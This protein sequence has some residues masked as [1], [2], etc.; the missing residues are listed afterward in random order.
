LD[1]NSVL[2]KLNQYNTYLLKLKDDTKKNVI[3]NYLQY[4]FHKGIIDPTNQIQAQSPIDEVTKGLKALAKTNT[5]VSEENKKLSE[6]NYFSNTSQFRE[7]HQGKDGIS[8]AAVGTKTYGV[9]SYSIHKILNSGNL[10]EIKTL[11]GKHTKK[12]LKSIHLEGPILENLRQVN[13]ALYYHIKDS[14]KSNN[15]IDDISAFMSLSVDNAKELALAALN[16]GFLTLGLY[17]YA[18]SMG[19][20][21]EKVAQALMSP[22]GNLILD[23]SKGNIFTGKRNA[24]SLESVFS[25]LENPVRLQHLF[26]SKEGRYVKKAWDAYLSKEVYAQLVLGKNTDYDYLFNTFINPSINS[27]ID[28]IKNNLPSDKYDKVAII[29]IATQLV[30]IINEDFKN[31]KLIQ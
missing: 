27:F 24:I 13:E 17:M 15:A 10:D 28:K 19:Y 20:D 31:K 23:S 3:L 12:F 4:N 22:I 18:I 5:V 1:A 16:A 9:L 7:N 26:K 29:Q 30:S 14:L 8:I 11:A 21:T 25:D 6:F 2:Q